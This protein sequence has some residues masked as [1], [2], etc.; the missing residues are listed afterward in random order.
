[1]NASALVKERTSCTGAVRSVS[2]CLCLLGQENKPIGTSILQLSVIDLD[3]SHNGPPFDF[4]IL[5]GNEGG[6]FVLERDG[7]LVANQ[8]FRRDLAAEYVIH[9]LVTYFYYIT[10]K[11]RAIFSSNVQV[12]IFCQRHR[13]PEIRSPMEGKVTW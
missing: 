1:M 6:E 12:N 8:V 4:R 3:S 13:G 9:I 7:T 10:F 5:S 11:T 2:P